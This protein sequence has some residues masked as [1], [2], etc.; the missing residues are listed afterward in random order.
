MTAKKIVILG[1]TGSIGTNALDVIGNHPDRFDVVGLAAG[2]NVDKLAKQIEQFHPE[3]VAVK[4]KSTAEALKNHVRGINGT[5]IVWGEEG[6]LEVATLGNADLVLSAIVGAAGLKPTYAALKAGKTVALANKESLVAAGEVM[7]KAQ[8]EGNAT[9]LPVDSEHSAIHQVLKGNPKEVVRIIL[10]A[11]GG[12]FRSVSAKGLEKVSVEEALKHPNWSMGEKIT[13]D[14]ATLMNKG[15]EIIEA[16]WLFKLPPE[17]ISVKIHPQSIVHSLVEYVDGSVLAQL[18]WPDMRT[19][20]AYALA[21]P[22]RIETKCRSLDLVA[23]SPLTFEEPDTKRFPCL[24]LAR[25][26]LEMGRTFPCVLNAANEVA[27]AAFLRRQTT[28]LGIPSLVEKV[29]ETHEAF[30]LKTLE[31]VL[32]ADRWARRK[33]ESLLKV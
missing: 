12:P 33:A 16:H 24:N 18:G 5:K 25:Q 22:E 29:L 28:F 11:S 6:F 27:V 21:Y 30:D 9:L 23:T 4:E 13:V 17:K 8:A 19:P 1:S 26:A 3:I 10:T 20:I 2:A 32:E 14:S 7:T 31:D 15:L